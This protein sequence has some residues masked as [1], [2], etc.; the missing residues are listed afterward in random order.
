MRGSLLFRCAGALC[1]LLLSLRTDGET[2]NKIN[3][4]C[5]IAWGDLEP[6][7]EYKTVEFE[8]STSWISPLIEIAR[9]YIDITLDEI[10]PPDDIANALGGQGSVFDA[11][12]TRQ[13]RQEKERAEKK[14]TEEGRE[15][16]MW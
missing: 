9:F 16:A 13:R 1:I 10:L 6:D 4:D 3:D 7:V 2:E 5:T 15:K 14:S 8:T 12:T 11:I